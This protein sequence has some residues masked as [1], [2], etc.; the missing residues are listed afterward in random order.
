[1]HF[2]NLLVLFVSRVG[3]WMRTSRAT[4]LGPT[5]IGD[6]NLWVNFCGECEHKTSFY[7]IQTCL[8]TG[9]VLNGL[10]GLGC[11]WWFDIKLPSM[12]FLCIEIYC[13]SCAWLFVSSPFK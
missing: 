4:I 3:L 9:Q 12:P 7:D 6:K 13:L 10:R 1:M 2:V 11:C 8:E 5:F